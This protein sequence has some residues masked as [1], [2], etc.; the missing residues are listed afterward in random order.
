MSKD[1]Q[2]MF[3]KFAAVT[4]PDTVSQ[5]R[6]ELHQAVSEH[7]RAM[8]AA[9]SGELTPAILAE[10]DSL[11]DAPG[12]LVFVI[13][14]ALG[15]G[16]GELRKALGRKKH[17]TCKRCGNRFQVIER[18]VKGGYSS[19]EAICPECRKEEREEYAEESRAD[20]K[21]ARYRARV[22]AQLQVAADPLAL[23]AFLAH[24]REYAAAWVA[25]VDYMRGPFGEIVCRHETGCMVCGRESPDMFVA[26]SAGVLNND[27][28]TVARN[29]AGGVLGFAEYEDVKWPLLTTHYQVLWRLD[30]ATYF[31]EFSHFPLTK[32]VVVFLCV[33][34][35]E[36]VARTHT[37]VS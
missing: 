35:A 9:G 13:A 32:M 7:L 23:D 10:A 30:P 12:G 14:Q 27:F 25:G 4:E 15:M 16:Q 26:R 3:E 1:L 29:L 24:L 34:H 37:R 20:H 22:D 18:R 8:V 19:P 2:A 6:E 28:W 11:Y 36:L 33:E 21:A 31:A 17:L 5:A